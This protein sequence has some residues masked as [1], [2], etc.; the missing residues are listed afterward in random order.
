MTTSSADVLAEQL[1]DPEFRAEWERTEA[2]RQLAHRIIA[3]RVERNLTQRDLAR[4]LATTQSAVAR[5]ESGEHEPTLR[6]IRKI[7]VRLGIAFRIEVTADHL[8][9]AC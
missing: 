1:Q 3:Y 4:L 8:A 9:I 7:A 6:T 5:L 2:A